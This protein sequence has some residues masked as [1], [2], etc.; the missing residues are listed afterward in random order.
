MVKPTIIYIFDYILV[1]FY[2]VCKLK[3]EMILFKLEK[4]ED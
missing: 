2:L 3:Y 1:Y 4:L